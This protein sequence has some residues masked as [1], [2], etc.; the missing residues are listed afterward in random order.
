[1]YFFILENISSYSDVKKLAIEE[2]I[3]YVEK[4]RQ[5]LLN[6]D[7]SVFID[8]IYFCSLDIIE[9]HLKKVGLDLTVQHKTSFVRNDH[10]GLMV[11]SVASLK[12]YIRNRVELCL[13]VKQ[14]LDLKRKN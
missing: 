2:D 3:K 14:I 8:N 4:T 7:S 10:Q 9:H 13:S 5:E 1:M 6:M 11:K 12:F